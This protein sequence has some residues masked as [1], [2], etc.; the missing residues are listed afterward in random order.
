MSIAAAIVRSPIAIGAVVGAALWFITGGTP[1]ADVVPVTDDTVVA[2]EAKKVPR[3]RKMVVKS[4]DVFEGEEFS[5]LDFLREAERSADVDDMEE[6]PL[7]D[8]ESG[9]DSDEAESGSESEFESESES[10]E[11]EMQKKKKKRKGKK[12]LPTVVRGRR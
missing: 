5:D 3:R 10:E 7:S 12:T 2:S 6:M 8:I 4:G 9:S 11:E 1:A